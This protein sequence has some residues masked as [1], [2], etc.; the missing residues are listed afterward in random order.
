MA[1]PS[2]RLPAPVHRLTKK[3]A[4]GSP[5]ARP[6]TEA[7]MAAQADDE[8]EAAW[9]SYLIPSIGEEVLRNKLGRTWAEPFGC[10]DKRELIRLEERF[11]AFRMIELQQRPVQGDFSLRHMKAIHGHLFQDVYEW[12]GEHRTVDMI[13]EGHDYMAHFQIERLWGKVSDFVERNNRFQDIDDPAVFAD[14]LAFVWGRVNVIHAFREGNTRSQVLFFDQLCQQAGF[15]LDVARLAPDHPDSV[16]DDF[17]AARFHHQDN[18]YDHD[19]LAAVLTKIV[20]PVEATPEQRLERAATLRPE[21]SR[22]APQAKQSVPREQTDYSN[23]DKMRTAH[24][25]GAR[26]NQEHHAMAIDPSK[27]TQPVPPRPGSIRSRFRSAEQTP[28]PTTENQL[29]SD[30]WQQP[31]PDLKPEFWD[32]GTTRAAA[33]SS[34][35][36]PVNTVV[37][38]RTRHGMSL[39]SPEDESPTDALI[40]DGRYPTQDEVDEWEKTA[41]DMAARDAADRAA[42]APRWLDDRYNRFPELAPPFPNVTPR[43]NTARHRATENDTP[44]L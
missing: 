34:T 1:V 14:K 35:Q 38:G 16:R 29:P 13:K 28:A 25:R 33:A 26:T 5:E 9:Q 8:R 30:F 41:P 18:G 3:G 15:E 19:P 36:T 4:G 32:D 27:S 22:W 31:E 23:P 20:R 24:R 17:V 6:A 39:T 21:Q 7:E 2:R 42:K 10:P 44:S 40:D 11:T 37:V 12:A 43:P